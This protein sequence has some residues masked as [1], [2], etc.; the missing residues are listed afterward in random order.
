VRGGEDGDLGHLGA[1]IDDARLAL[2][3]DGPLEVARHL[4]RDDRD[5][6]S[7]SFRG[8]GNLHELCT[9]ASASSAYILL[10]TAAQPTFFCSMSLAFGQS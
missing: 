1:D 5:V 8:Q 6:G 4:V 7:E 10:D 3:V 9:A 2:E